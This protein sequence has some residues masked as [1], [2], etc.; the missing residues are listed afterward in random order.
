M[1]RWW[2]CGREEEVKKNSESERNDR[3]MIDTDR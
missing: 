1:E 3:C 2:W